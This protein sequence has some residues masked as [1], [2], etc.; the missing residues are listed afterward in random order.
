MEL[1]TY[2]GTKFVDGYEWQVWKPKKDKPK[3]KPKEI[4]WPYTYEGTKFIDGYEWQVWK[5]KKYY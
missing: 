2:E 5:P 1:Y 4:E 3:E